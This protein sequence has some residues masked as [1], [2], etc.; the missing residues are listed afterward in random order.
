MSFNPSIDRDQTL[1]AA[2][3]AIRTGET[4]RGRA[5]LARVLRVNPSCESAWLWMA[6]IVEA[7]QQRRECL[8]RALAI[9]PQNGLARR[10]LESLGVTAPPVAT[11]LT[12][13]TADPA[14][15]DP[16]MRVDAVRC[17]N[18]GAGID[19]ADPRCHFCGS[20]LDT[21]L[22]SPA[23]RSSPV[24]QKRE[25]LS[26]TE[27]KELG[28]GFDRQSCG[29][30]VLFFVTSLLGCIGAASIES[31]G[32]RFGPL[33]A[34]FMGILSTLLVFLPFIVPIVAQHIEETQLMKGSQAEARIIDMWVEDE[35]E[36]VAWEFAVPDQG[37]GVVR[38][39][40]K[41]RISSNIYSALEARDTVLVRYNPQKPQKS[42]LDK[43][44]LSEI[45]KR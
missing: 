33:V 10:E 38:F 21:S 27:R 37:G 34:L 39:R 4:E 28:S 7:P 25:P 24:V 20:L 35:Y 43:Q 11:M 9:N 40:N 14:T 5:L 16:S 3:T 15:P 30:V 26:E 13:R 41:Q 44:W 29:V 22:Y 42:A 36:Y 23:S 12:Q 6:T 2:I 1:N 45:V 18:C 17:P 19:S 8:E 32:A 31:L